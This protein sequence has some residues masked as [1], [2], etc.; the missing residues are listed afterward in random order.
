MRGEVTVVVEGGHDAVPHDQE[1]L[2][3]EVRRLVENGMRTDAA[4][5]VAERHGASA[6]E[7]YRA[8]IAEA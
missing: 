1:A 4:R 7:L 2:V 6:N 8:A 5:A 3:D